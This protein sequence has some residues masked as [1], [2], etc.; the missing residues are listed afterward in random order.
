MRLLYLYAGP[1]CDYVTV[2]DTTVGVAT[3][4]TLIQTHLDSIKLTPAANDQVNSTRHFII[5]YFYFITEHRH[6]VSFST[7][8]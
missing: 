3:T 6:T 1:L 8:L 4:P 7:A 5:G 2:Q